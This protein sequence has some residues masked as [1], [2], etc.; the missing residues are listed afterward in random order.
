MIMSRPLGFGGINMDTNGFVYGVCVGELS[1][2]PLRLAENIFYL[3]G[4]M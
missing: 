1:A 4:R 2:S 3:G